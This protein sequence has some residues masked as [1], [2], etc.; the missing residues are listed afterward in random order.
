M[1]RR[2]FAYVSVIVGALLGTDAAALKHAIKSP[3]ITK[4]SRTDV[5][6]TTISENTMPPQTRCADN[7]GIT[8]TTGP[9]YGVDGS[10]LSSV[11]AVVYCNPSLVKITK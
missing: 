7:N 8:I 11:D 5:Q 9:L 3:E 6:V 4:K 2:E 10:R 1:T